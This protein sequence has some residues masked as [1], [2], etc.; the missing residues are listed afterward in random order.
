M[1]SERLDQ[2]LPEARRIAMEAGAR[3]M[4][5]YRA[6]FKV[7]EKANGSPVTTADLA[8]HQHIVERLE[9]LDESLPVLSEESPDL[10]SWETRRNWDSYWLVDPLDGTRELI[11]K[12]EEFTVN[13]GLIHQRRPVLGVVGVPASGALYHARRGGG[14][15]RAREEEKPVAIHSRPFPTDGSSVVAISFSHGRPEVQHL[16]SL[17]G[18]HQEKRVGS[19]LKSCHVAEGSLDLYPRYGSTSEWDTAAAQ[20]VVEEAGGKVVDW[21]L[22]P[23]RYNLRPDMINP[24]F[25]VIG[26][27]D[28]DWASLMDQLPRSDVEA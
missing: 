15:W 24:H 22:R 28:H 26:D 7:F 16:L 20:C 10:P 5:I 3:V 17:L 19:S 11:R 25:L 8:A 2:L 13:I 9:A 27:P 18:P 6:G 4:E 1:N 23:L 21:R 12:S 14:A